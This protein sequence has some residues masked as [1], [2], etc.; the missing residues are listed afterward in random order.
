MIFFSWFSSHS[1]PR[2]PHCGGFKITLRRMKLGR[3]LRTSHQPGNTTREHTT[4]T[5]DRQ[6]CPRRDSNPQS[7]PANG[8][9][10]TPQ[11]TR[12]P[13][14]ACQIYRN[15]INIYQNKEYY[16]ILKRVY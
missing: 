4:F 10:P 9:R 6:P 11:I 8:R 5:T 14:S 12:T 1:G 16:D 13:G 7:Q 3:L 2:Q 15:G